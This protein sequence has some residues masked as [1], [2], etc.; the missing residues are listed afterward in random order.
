MR[1]IFLLI[2]CMSIM[3]IGTPALSIEVSLLY[4]N[5]VSEIEG[6]NQDH[7]FRD[8]KLTV[9]EQIDNNLYVKFVHINE[10]H[11]V[12][13]HRDSFGGVISWRN[14]IIWDL[15]LEFEAG[16]ILTFDTTTKDDIQID[17]KNFGLLAS[18]GL[19]YPISDF[20]SVRAEW[21]KVY[22][23]TF[24]SDMYLIG[25]E[26][27]TDYSYSNSDSDY[28]VTFL[29]SS[30]KTNLAGTP[31][32]LGGIIDFKKSFNE[33]WSISAG[34]ISQGDDGKASRPI[35]A[36]VRLWKD[37]HLTQQFQIS[38]GIGPYYGKNELSDTSPLNGLISIQPYYQVNKKWGIVGEFSRI[39]DFSGNIDADIFSIGIRY[40]I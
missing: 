25:L 34:L 13:H 7:N 33:D 35:G 17:D 14:P 29:L 8:F 26:F 18:A 15:N 11:P 32:T 21:N 10:G 22:V 1:T 40:K 9:G 6:E 3:S 36:A 27:T 16:P 2:I 20:V 5:G 4:G 19:I 39:A 31:D 30:Y 38:T 28:S 37:F 12:D 23:S 24:N